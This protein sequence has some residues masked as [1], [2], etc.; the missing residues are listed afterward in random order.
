MYDWEYELHYDKSDK[1]VILSDLIWIDQD[2]T[3]ER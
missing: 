1:Q 2:T 3:T